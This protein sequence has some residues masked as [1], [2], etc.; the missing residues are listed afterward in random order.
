MMEHKNFVTTEE[1]SA[2]QHNI[3]T[4]IRFLASLTLLRNLMLPTLVA[5]VFAAAIPPY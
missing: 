5:I 2:Q 1:V 4:L 3:R